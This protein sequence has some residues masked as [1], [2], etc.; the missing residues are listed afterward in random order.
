MLLLSGFHLLMHLSAELPIQPSKVSALRSM[1]QGTPC[2]RCLPQNSLCPTTVPGTSQSNRLQRWLQLLCNFKLFLFKVILGLFQLWA[3]GQR[4][5]V[6][7]I[8]TWKNKLMETTNRK[9]VLQICFNIFI[10][11]VFKSLEFFCTKAT[12][13]S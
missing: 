6:W 5:E 11:S 4:Q 10:I 7:G 9:I 3:L 1:S 2:S 12:C 8:S 13:F